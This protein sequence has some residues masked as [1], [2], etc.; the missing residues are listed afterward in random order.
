[1]TVELTRIAE[2]AEFDTAAGSAPMQTLAHQ[3]QRHPLTPSTGAIV[4]GG[5]YRG[6]GIV[7]SLG[8]HGIPVWVLYDE[9]QLAARSRY[10][11][12]RAVWP[13]GGDEIHT[14]YLQYLCATYHLDG[15]AIFPTADETAAYVARQHEQ[16][17]KNFTLTT[18]PWEQFRWAYDKRL[19]NELADSL[20]IDHPR[21][22]RPASREELAS[23]D[24]VY[25]AIL[26]PAYKTTLN[27]FT[28]AKA[29][30]V[31]SNAELI[32][33]YDEACAFATPESILVQELI[34]GGGE[35]QL[36]FAALADN[37]QTIVSITARRTR[38]YPMD[39]GRASTFVETIEDA[40]VAE[41]GRRMIEGT[42]L[43][44]LVEVEFKRD[45]RTNRLHLLD[46]NPRVWG[47]HTLGERAGIDFSYLMWRHAFQLPVAEAQARPGVR[48][49]RGMTDFP[50]VFKEIIGRRL[51]LGDYLRSIRPPVEQAVLAL[52]DPLPAALEVP[53]TLRLIARRGTV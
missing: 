19:S 50:M 25:P 33:K 4:I 47:W 51:S 12:E 7:R 52:D 41:V 23:L 29:W 42:H 5:D 38:Q 35:S 2:H 36:S 26:K 39:F 18:A 3:T 28:L 48:W 6:L 45:P 53:L 43:T 17:A 21:T 15:W 34:P 16:L 32:E 37:G 1:M 44:G 20:G 11:K 22:W 31:N 9:H 14:R 13:D 8:R 27:Q 10:A 30:P 49:V 40:E 24:V 46:M